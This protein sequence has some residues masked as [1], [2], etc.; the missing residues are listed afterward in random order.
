MIDHSEK[1]GMLF[2]LTHAPLSGSLAR[3]S[4][5]AVMT[6]ALLNQAVSLL[7]VADG[8]YQLS[9]TEFADQLAAL[10]DLAPMELYAAEDDLQSR[11]LCQQH[12]S[13]AV[14]ALTPDQLQALFARHSQILSF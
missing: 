5:D 14:T 6:A 7:F 10:L 13:L 12:L 3:E 4:L 8:V 1:A 9:Q 2:V 11:R